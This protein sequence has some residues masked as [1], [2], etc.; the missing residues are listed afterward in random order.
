MTSIREMMQSKGRA[1]AARTEGSTPGKSREKSN[2]RTRLLPPPKVNSPEAPADPVGASRG[3]G[4]SSADQKAAVDDER[5]S[6]TVEDILRKCAEMGGVRVF[7]S[8]SGDRNLMFAHGR[9]LATMERDGLIAVAEDGSKRSV[10]LTDRGWRKIGM[11][12]PSDEASPEALMSIET[13]G[14]NPD[15]DREAW[16]R[17]ACSVAGSTGGE[18]DVDR[19]QAIFAEYQKV[20]G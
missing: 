7:S 4:R 16:L 19:I 5:K 14:R 11:D 6:P 15:R 20:C 18:S 10:A 12:P 8:R 2:G 9:T 3:A 17:I 1:M 13:Q